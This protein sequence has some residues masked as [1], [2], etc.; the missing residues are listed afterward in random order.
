[1]GLLKS[2]FL[3]L[4]SDSQTFDIAK[5]IHD[6]IQ[7]MTGYNSSLSPIELDKAVM[8]ITNDK[9]IAQ[10]VLQAAGFIN[11]YENHKPID[12][13]KVFDAILEELNKRLHLTSKGILSGKVKITIYED[14]KFSIVNT[15]NNSAHELFFLLYMIDRVLYEIEEPK[16]MQNIAAMA[17]R[18]MS[19][20]KNGRS[21]LS[22]FFDNYQKNTNESL[23]VVFEVSHELLSKPKMGGEHLYVWTEY[24]PTYVD[25]FDGKLGIATMLYVIDLMNRLDND[26][27]KFC[28]DAYMAM[29]QL[30]FNTKFPTLETITVAP[31]IIINKMLKS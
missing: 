6:D 28:A 13:N 2:L 26:D 24:S 10:R 20:L 9:I 30:Y 14:N 12:F 15:F 17:S 5:R 23:D 25:N 22:N 31:S 8:L 7:C 11:M 3:A 18:Y 27:Q 16:H 29:L 19:D 4:K 1:M 21:E